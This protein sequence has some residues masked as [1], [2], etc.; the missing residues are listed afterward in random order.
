MSAMKF[1]TEHD[2][3]HYDGRVA[4]RREV[5]KDIEPVLR[6]AWELLIDP[7]WSNVP[8]VDCSHTDCNL[9]R[10]VE[11]SVEAQRVKRNMENN[12]K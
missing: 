4:G 3:I 8:C 2:K 11:A 5:R 9:D 7:N 10:A 12:K 1:D 6:A